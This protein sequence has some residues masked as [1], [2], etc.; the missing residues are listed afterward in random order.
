MNYDKTFQYLV[1]DICIV[2]NTKKQ[3]SLWSSQEAS[4]FDWW[5]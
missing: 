5:Q 2:L 3:L 1:M 4:F